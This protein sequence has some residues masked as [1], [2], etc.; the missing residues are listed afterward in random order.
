M[1]PAANRISWWRDLS[2]AGWAHVLYVVGELTLL[3]GFLLHTTPIA[4]VLVV[5]TI[6]TIHV[7]IGLLQPRDFL[8]GHTARVAA[9]P[10]LLT[11]L[12]MVWIV[13]AAK[14]LALQ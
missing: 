4:V 9:S 1:W 13:S 11:C 12:G 5:V 2:W 6:L 10:L 14:L 3:L 8:S 7:P